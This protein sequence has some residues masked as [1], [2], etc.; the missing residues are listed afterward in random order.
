MITVKGFITVD[1]LI[2]NEAGVIAPIGELSP[3]GRTYSRYKEIHHNDSSP[4]TRYVHFHAKDDAG[5]RIE[6]SDIAVNGALDMGAWVIDYVDNNITVSDPTHITEA[7]KEAYPTY[8]EISVGEQLRVG[9]D[10]YP[11]TVYYV[12][13]ANDYSLTLWFAD[14]YFRR[15]YPEYEIVVIHPVRE[16]DNMLLPYNEFMIDLANYTYDVQIDRLSEVGEEH[17]YTVSRSHTYKWYDQDDQTLTTDVSWTVA[18]YGLAGDNLERIQE[19]IIAAVFAVTAGTPE[20]WQT[21]VPDLFSPTEFLLIPAWQSIA[22]NSTEQDNGIHSPISNVKDQAGI[23]GIILSDLDEDHVEDNIE[24]TTAIYKSVAMMALGQR[25]NRAGK[26]RLSDMFPDY[27]LASTISSDFA[28]M[29]PL[30]QEWVILL[31]DLLLN[32]DTY[33]FSSPLP[34]NMVLVTRNNV[35]YVL[36]QYDGTQYLVAER[37]SYMKAIDGGTDD[38]E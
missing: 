10:W 30:T 15:D 33:A 37:T 34:P 36:S 9:D 6:P 23:A 3:V 27:I 26:F 12:D 13:S 22:I 28:R 29:S 18:I 21:A 32:A 19:D 7:L 4:G 31:Q 5:D 2:D 8:T 17:P 25:T 16:V 14:E 11:S 24:I 35:D 20:Q 1:K 38:S